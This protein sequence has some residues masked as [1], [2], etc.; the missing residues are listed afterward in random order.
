METV[1]LRLEAELER[2]A[3]SRRWLAV[4]VLVFGLLSLATWWGTHERLPRR[5]R[6]AS[7]EPGGL[8]H[9]V[10]YELAQRIMVRTGREVVVLETRGSVANRELL[11][12]G[13]ADLAVIQAGTVDLTGLDA[14]V[15]LYP[16]VVHVV[17]RAGRGIERMADLSGRRLAIGQRG[18]GN[19]VLA[20]HLLRHY[21][22]EVAPIEEAEQYFVSMLRDETIDGA[23]ISTGLLNPDLRRVLAQREFHLLPILDADALGVRHYFL[24]AA[25]IP[26]GLFAEGP[27]VP[28]ETVPTVSTTA[29]LMASTDVAPR[30]VR[31]ARDALFQPDMRASF[32]ILHSRRD[33]LEWSD[34]V[35]SPDARA[36]FDP[37][38]GVG[39]LGDFVQSVAAIKELLFAIGAGVYLAW[40]YR[41]RR[42]ASRRTREVDQQ[43]E[44]LGRLLDATV[45]VERA[46]MTATAP[47]ELRKCLDQVTR[48]KVEALESLTHA[49]LRG[50]RLFS[51]FLLQCGNLSRKIQ[52]KI[53]ASGLYHPSFGGSSAEPG[54]EG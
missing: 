39:L 49:D 4:G 23:I 36:Y 7:A 14:V 53:V 51:I 25:A 52:D 31:E 43:K 17:V 32:P 16:D 30:L 28:P 18:S 50:D 1:E 37:Y 21:G 42:R 45:R 6:I 48:L 3:G 29:V 10:A 46:Q 54:E 2:R 5:I 8:Y 47:A 38:A 9:R 20:G 15:P 44:H 34:M 27:P 41:R 26:R 35:L 24:R 19:R 13:A 12:S 22:V 33:V 40:D 11:R